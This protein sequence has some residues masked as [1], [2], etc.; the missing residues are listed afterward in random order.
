[1]LITQCSH[2]PHCLVLQG[3]FYLIQDL[4]TSQVDNPLAFLEQ[5]QQKILSCFIFNCGPNT[6]WNLKTVFLCLML[7]W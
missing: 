4:Q 7:S 6:H 2:C 3:Q 5:Q 1:M